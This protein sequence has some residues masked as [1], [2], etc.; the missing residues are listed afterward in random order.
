MFDEKDNVV[1]RDKLFTAMTRTK[2][3]LY[4]SGIGKS[5]DYLKNE[6]GLL[7]KNN[8]KLIFRQPDE[9]DTK[10]IEN[11]SRATLRAED[12]IANQINT[13]KELGLDD[14]G[15]KTILEKLVKKA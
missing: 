9:S 13:L 3:W 12:A 7:K 14:D 11:V 5:M 2:G 4:I 1:L 6:I 8:F 10:N 15:I